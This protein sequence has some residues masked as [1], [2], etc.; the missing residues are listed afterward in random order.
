ME[1]YIFTGYVICGTAWSSK[2]KHTFTWCVL[3][4]VNSVLG[5][6]ARCDCNC[7]LDH[8]AACKGLS[9]TTTC[10]LGCMFTWS[11]L[12]GCGVHYILFGKFATCVGQKH[13]AHFLFGP[14]FFPKKI[15][16]FYSMFPLLRPSLS[17]GLTTHLSIWCAPWWAYDFNCILGHVLFTWIMLWDCSGHFDPNPALL[18]RG[19]AHLMWHRG[20]QKRLQSPPLGEWAV[21]TTEYTWQASCC[22]L[23]PP[24]PFMHLNFGPV[25]RGN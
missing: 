22:T 14:W 5:L 16:V 20:W 3:W 25:G 4:S 12:C 24:T 6:G 10:N 11:T 1:V 2:L 15:F 21:V 7:I 8:G 23:R 13:H 9:A 17:P 18:H 19:A